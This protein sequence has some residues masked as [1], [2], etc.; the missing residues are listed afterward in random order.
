[1]LADRDAHDDGMAV[2]AS[3]TA[4]DEDDAAGLVAT[5]ALIHDELGTA[6]DFRDRIGSALGGPRTRPGICPVSSLGR[7]VL[8]HRG[9]PS[10]RR[11]LLQRREDDAAVVP[12]LGRPAL[13]Q[14][15]RLNRSRPKR[16]ATP[17]SR[18]A[19]VDPL[20]AV[21]GRQGDDDLSVPNVATPSARLDWPT[22]VGIV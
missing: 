21:S 16:E 4:L 20:A 12:V 2:A 22:Y 15:W 9:V 7:P 19:S 8:G 5:S 14:V 6:P 18:L 1:M 11:F 10:C 13:H 17:G 3:W